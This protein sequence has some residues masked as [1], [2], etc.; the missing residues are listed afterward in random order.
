MKVIQIVGTSGT[1]KT[2]FI[3]DLIPHLSSYGK[4]AIIKH[5]GHHT[6]PLE[7]GK[8]TTYFFEAGTSYSIGIDPQK[9]V[10]LT[11]DADLRTVLHM[12][13]DAGVTMTI[14]EGFKSI[15]FPRIV[16]GD[17]VSSEVVLRNPTATEVIQNLTR[18]HTIN[19]IPGLVH[20]L[21][22]I[23]ETGENDALCTIR[24]SLEGRTD[25]DPNALEQQIAAQSGV[26][27]VRVATDEREGHTHVLVVVR[28]EDGKSAFRALRLVE[29]IDGHE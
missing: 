21:V 8:D 11:R 2:T 24:L 22:G 9:A 6:F 20:E 7:E 12:L 4:I 5:L 28:A 17:L 13:C 14:V 27:G 10:I 18:F 3:R 16:F 15:L 25:V 26:I 19:T 23:K 1:G 29:G